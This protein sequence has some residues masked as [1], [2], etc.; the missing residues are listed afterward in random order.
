MFKCDEPTCNWAHL[1][2][3]A[4]PHLPTFATF[5]V[6]TLVNSG[7]YYGPYLNKEYGFNDSEVPLIYSF[8]CYPSLHELCI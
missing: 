4:R 5:F 1:L 2:L 3:L 8:I 6:Y 7:G